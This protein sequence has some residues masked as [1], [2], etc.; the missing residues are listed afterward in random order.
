[1]SVFRDSSSTDDDDEPSEDMLINDEL[2][3]KECIRAKVQN[4]AL[5]FG[6]GRRRKKNPSNDIEKVAIWY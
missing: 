6:C 4:V 3:S 2:R 1:M 5:N